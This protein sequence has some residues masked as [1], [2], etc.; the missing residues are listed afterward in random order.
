MVVPDCI[1]NDQPR[2]L[3]LLSFISL[4]C[5]INSLYRFVHATVCQPFDLGQYIVNFALEI[6]ILPLN[7]SKF[8]TNLWGCLASYFVSS[9]LS[10]LWPLP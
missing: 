3:V 6:Y 8:R 10:T 1:T 2:Y 9:L 4:S 7:W 5:I